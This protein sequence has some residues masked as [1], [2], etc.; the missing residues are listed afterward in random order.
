M[1]AHRWLQSASSSFSEFLLDNGLG[2]GVHRLDQIQE[3]LNERLGFILDSQ[4][5]LP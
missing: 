3:R 5:C 2:V 1:I 4:L